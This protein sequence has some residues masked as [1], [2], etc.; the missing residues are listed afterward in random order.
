MFADVITERPRLELLVGPL[1]GA[2]NGLIE[3]EVNAFIASD[4]FADLWIAVNT[5]AQQ[6]LVQLLNGDES[7]ALSVQNGEVVLD[8]SAV[9]E[10]V[11]NRL[12]ARGLTV[13]EN[14]PIPDVDKQIVLLD[15]PQVEQARTIYAFTN[16]VA[17]WLI[18]AVAALYVAAFF[19]ARRRVAD[20]GGHWCW[21]GV[22]R[23]TGGVCFVSGA[24]TVR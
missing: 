7:G 24:S 9:I 20:G 5:R 23:P 6:A 2:I 17:K 15:A 8:L 3:R 1:S 21:S 22:Q 19:L 10:E 12:V 4:A 13:V 14:V 18:V 11:K 16:P